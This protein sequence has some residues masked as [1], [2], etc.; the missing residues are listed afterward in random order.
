MAIRYELPAEHPH[1]ALVTVDRPDKANA[2]D[3]S[4]LRVLAETWHAIAADQN[5]RC[6][7]LTGAGTRVFCAGMDMTTTI[8]VSQRLARGERVPQEDFEGLR[9][10]Q[11]ALL[12]G[13]DLGT[14]LVCAL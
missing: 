6:A 3:L 1:V 2:L 13:F 8:P 9:S 11:T 10:V 14:P 4:M 7:V 5:V 12:A